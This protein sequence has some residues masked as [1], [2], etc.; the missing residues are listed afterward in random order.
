MP[1]L[2]YIS[3]LATVA[4]VANYPIV[5]NDIDIKP[6]CQAS[7]NSRLIAHSLALEMNWR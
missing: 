4:A 5:A 3:S 2:L 7:A 6:V 1:K